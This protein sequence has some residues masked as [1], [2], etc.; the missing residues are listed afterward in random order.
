MHDDD[1]LYTKKPLAFCIDSPSVLHIGLA[2]RVHCWLQPTQ[3]NSAS[4]AASAFG[5]ADRAVDSIMRGCAAYNWA[6][7]HTCVDEIH[8][9]GTI[10]NIETSYFTQLKMCY[11]M[12]TFRCPTSVG[13]L[14]HVLIVYSLMELGVHTILTSHC[15]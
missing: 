12:T 4:A 9:V 3:P 13:H 14:D 7:V 8:L 15:Y 6:G 2:R 1:Q 10:N 5:A 11:L